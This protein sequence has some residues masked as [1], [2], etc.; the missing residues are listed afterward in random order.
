ASPAHLDVV[1]TFKRCLD[2]KAAA[3][4]EGRTDHR[5]LD[6]LDDQLALEGARL[7][8]RRVQLLRELEPHVRR[9][10]GEI[11]AG[12]ATLGLRYRTAGEGDEPARRAERLREAFA[13]VRGEELRRGTALAG[14]QRDDV[15]VQLD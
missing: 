13:R 2:Q 15:A 9:L 12:G 1:R 4:R 11:A 10:H 7:V 8:E 6:A 5:V 14:P 3:L